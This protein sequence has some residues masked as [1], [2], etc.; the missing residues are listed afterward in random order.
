MRTEIELPISSLPYH[1]VILWQS[2]WSTT[3]HA[4]KASP[5]LKS[6]LGTYEDGN[7]NNETKRILKQLPDLVY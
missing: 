2:A 3:A 1:Q 7:E 5:L 4:E 6:D